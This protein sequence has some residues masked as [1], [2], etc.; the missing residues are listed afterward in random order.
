MR[1]IQQKQSFMAAFLAVLLFMASCSSTTLISSYPSGA[2]I[3]INDEFV[4]VTPYKY[5]DT[6]IVGSRNYVTLKKEGYEEL[7]TSFSRTE[8]LSVGALIG[9]LFVTIP[10]LWIMQYKDTH[11]Y[12]LKPI[13]VPMKPE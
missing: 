1:A 11:N 13:Q 7:Q 8:E 6:K 10:F 9:G 4:G 5:K 3:Y 12:E 2:K